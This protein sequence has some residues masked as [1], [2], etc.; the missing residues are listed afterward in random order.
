MCMPALTFL[1]VVP[2]KTYFLYKFFK[3]LSEVTQDCPPV[4]KFV[5]CFRHKQ[6]IY[7][8]LMDV[9]RERFPDCEIV[10]FDRYPDE[11]LGQEGFWDI[12]KGCQSILIIDDCSDLIGSSFEYLCRGLCHHKSISLFYVSQDHSGEPKVVKNALKNM[13]YLL[14]FKQ[15][16][17]GLLLQD[18]N[19]RIFPYERRF[20]SQCYDKVM[21]QLG[22]YN[23]L[24]ID[25]S[26][27]CDKYR[28]VKTGL[29]DD[30]PKMLFELISAHS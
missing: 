12:P 19:R 1:T 6:P 2:G 10:T 11:I 17:S 23:Y 5:L 3:F 14:L 24:L 16:L 28:S 8:K 4:A 21:S 27:G 30:E 9:I 15:N 13:T 25:K 20:L 26:V 18:L 29:F 22:L 7:E